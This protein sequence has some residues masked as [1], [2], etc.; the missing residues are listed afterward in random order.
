M[1][2]WYLN[3]DTLAG[4]RFM[5]SPLAETFA[6][7]KLLHAGAASHPG[8]RAWLDTHL[9]A[10]RRLLADDPV[11]ALLVRSGLGREWIADFLTPTPREQ[12]SFEEGVARVRTASPAVA[13]AHLTVSLRGPL[14]ARL[15]RDDLPERAAELLTYVWTRTVRPYWDRRRRILEADVVARTAQFGRGGWAAAVDTLRPGRTRWLGG[16]RLQVNLH[17]YP[18]REISGAELLFVPVTPQTGWVSWEETDRYA[19]VYPCAGVLAQGPR[20][21]V[22]ESLGTLLGPARAGVLVLLDSPMSTS[23]L[24]AVTGQGLGT[25][26]RHLK[27]L[28]DARLV[29]RRRTGRSVL[30]SRTAAGEVLVTAQRD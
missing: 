27:V 7:L 8:E 29:D 4:S 5:V 9:P 12:E 25:V 1:S 22:P 17:E 6:S 24:V 26:G 30:Y 3:A 28:L 10:Y 11:T 20:T 2:L 19:V 16:N 18:P 23:Q 14:P 21:E 13:R 15:D